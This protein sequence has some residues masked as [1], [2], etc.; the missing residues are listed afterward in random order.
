VESCG[1]GR[2]LLDQGEIAGI[3]WPELF[4]QQLYMVECFNM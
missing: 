1:I 2:M 4:C 3:P